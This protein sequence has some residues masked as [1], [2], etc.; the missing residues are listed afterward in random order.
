MDAKLLKEKLKQFIS[1]F[2]VWKI[3]DYSYNIEVEEGKSFKENLAEN[4]LWA[5]GVPRELETFYNMMSDLD[6]TSFW[7][8]SSTVEDIRKVHINL[9]EII[10]N[11]LCDL[12]AKDLLEISVDDEYYNKKWLEIEKDN[13]FKN[14]LDKITREVLIYGDGAFKIG[15]KPDIQDTPFISFERAENIEYVY[16]DGRIKDIIFKKKYKV[17][18]LTYYLLE[19]YGNGYIKYKLVNEN[20]VGVPLSSVPELKDLKDIL[21]LKADGEIDRK[22]RLAIPYKVWDSTLYEGRGKS[23]FDDKKQAFDSLDEAWSTWIDAMRKGLTQRYIPTSLI[24]KDRYGNLLVKNDFRNNYIELDSGGLTFEN[25]T[26]PQVQCVQPQIDTNRYVA[27]YSSALDICLNGLLSP[28][29]LGIDT[30]KLENAE[31]QREKEKTSL[32]SREAI[33]NGM[34]IAIKQVVEICL[35]FDCYQHG[36]N[37]NSDYGINVVFNEYANPSFEAKVT[38]MAKACPNRQIISY[39]KVVNELYPNLSNEEKAE[40]ANRLYIINRGIDQKTTDQEL[41]IED[42]NAKSVVNGDS[43]EVEMEAEAQVSQEDKTSSL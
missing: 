20:M 1:N 29:T 15:F 14:S 41:I 19:F 26:S 7:G 2:F 9:P 18:N 36:E 27:F 17:G 10:L 8:A 32:R 16:E 5:R 11:T 35:R 24:P 28:S 22:I 13:D 40:E 21:F 39:E 3:K 30:K 25:G 6:R 23:I 37:Y 4:R 43:R 12:T 42:D 38:V 33:I 34:N 31:S